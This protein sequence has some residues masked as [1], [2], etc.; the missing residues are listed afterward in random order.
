MWAKVDDQLHSHPKWLEVSLSARGLWTTCLS[1]TCGHGTDGFVP[2][3][4]VRMHAGADTDALAAEL[5]GIGLWDAEEN[6]WRFHDFLLY[7]PSAEEVVEHEAHVSTVRAE[8]GR[9]SGESRRNKARTN[10]EQNTNKN[11][12]RPRPRSQYTESSLSPASAHEEPPVE[13]SEPPAPPLPAEPT[14][15]RLRELFIA[16]RSRRFPS[17]VPEEFPEAEL[18]RAT[19]DLQQLLAAGAT[20]A[21]VHRATAAAMRRWGDPATEGGDPKFV[22]V[23]SVAGNWSA[24][25]EDDPPPRAPAPESRYGRPGAPSRRRETPEEARAAIRRDFDRIAEEAYS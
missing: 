6:G 17:L 3:S 24:L 14:S 15:R 10:A 19:A 12:P 21:D 7:N 11:E 2:R 9:K 4:F 8:A 13:A 16:Y 18:R 1:W 25:L 23:A 22:T 20:T 5:V